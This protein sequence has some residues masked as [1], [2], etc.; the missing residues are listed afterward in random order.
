VTP[1]ADPLF[2]AFAVPAVFLMAMG[3]GGFGGNLA[4]LAMPVMAMSAPPVQAAAIMMPILLIMDAISCWAWRRTWSREN[5]AIMLPAGIA[6][7]L[8]GY[9]TASMVSDAALRLMIGLL[10]LAFCLQAWLTRTRDL[11]PRR[12][13]WARGSFWSGISGFT[14]F[15]S[16]VGGPQLAVYLLPQKLS[17]EVLAGTFTIH[18]AIINIVKTPGFLA[19]GAFTPQNLWTSAALAP[20]AALG[21]VFGVWLVK[22]VSTE[23][24]YRIMY[25][26]LFV[27]ALKL[28]VDGV[29]GLAG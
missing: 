2:Y 16:H 14:S 22:R 11:P 3:K 5:V 1:I 6:G 23:L 21:T 13:D 8:V 20:V 12:P 10:G 7:T 17:K 27:V 18:F 24:F 25:L 9:L 4:V 28:I 19:L 15:I 26:I 29:R